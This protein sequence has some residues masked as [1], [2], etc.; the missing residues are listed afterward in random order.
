MHRRHM[1]WLVDVLTAFARATVQQW[2]ALNHGSR[3]HDTPCRCSSAALQDTTQGHDDTQLIHH[4]HQ[5]SKEQQKLR[6]LTWWHVYV[7]VHVG[8]VGQR[9]C[10]TICVLVPIHELIQVALAEG[11]EVPRPLQH[12]C[13]V[14]R[15]MHRV[16]K[17]RDTHTLPA[18]TSL[19]G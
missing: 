6:S 13:V 2:H 1:P 17:Q 18:C 7:L 14:A 3:K 15:N 12:I 4:N 10:H 11:V 19:A 9:K 16:G 8:L 5:N